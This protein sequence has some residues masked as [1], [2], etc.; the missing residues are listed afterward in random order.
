MN[1]TQSHHNTSSCTTASYTT[2]V[3]NK[4]NAIDSATSLD[5]SLYD[6][7]YFQVQAHICHKQNMNIYIYITSFSITESKCTSP[8]LQN[9]G[10]V[11]TENNE[12]DNLP[13]RRKK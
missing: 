3:V 6:C 12:K 13:S 11:Q 8:D 1:H 7:G 9:T 5:C 4:A 2:P 10:R